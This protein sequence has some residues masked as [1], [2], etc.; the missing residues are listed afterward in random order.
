MEAALDHLVGPREEF[1]KI[2]S[3][4]DNESA[5]RRVEPWQIISEIT[6]HG[7]GVSKAIYELYREEDDAT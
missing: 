3:D 5:K 1:R 7:S 2:L 4:A 6:Y